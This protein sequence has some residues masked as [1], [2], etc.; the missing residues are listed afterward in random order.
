MLYL[1]PGW[2]HDG[3]AVGGDCMTARSAFARRSRDELARA[4]LHGVAES[5]RRTMTASL[6]P[7]PARQRR[8][9]TPGARA[10][11]AAGALRAHAWR[12]A[13]RDP[14][15]LERALGEWLTEPKPQVWFEPGARPRHGARGGWRSTGARACCT[16]RTMSTST[17]SRSRA[18]ARCAC[19][20]RLAD[21]R[22]LAANE[23][24]RLSRDARGIVQ[25]WLASGWIH[26][27]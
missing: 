8:H 19:L 26:E 13:L 3:V 11:G 5:Q 6:V 4:L 14:R 22:R 16:T 9:G 25:Q 1:P 10:A 12:S 23:L 24:R 21:A 15:A 2:G 18:G 27:R 20:R 17:A 7:R